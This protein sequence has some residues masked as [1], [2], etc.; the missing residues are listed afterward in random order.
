MEEL[1]KKKGI[2]SK[3]KSLVAKTGRSIIWRGRPKDNEISEKIAQKIQKSSY[4]FSIMER[5]DTFT[6]PYLS[7]AEQLQVDDDQIFKAAAYNMANIAISRK[8]YAQDIQD[9]FNDYLQKEGMPEVRRDYIK[10]KQLEIILMKKYKKPASRKRL[11]YKGKII[12][13]PE[14]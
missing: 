7:L 9:I 10:Q 1:K 12:F 14:R 11:F 3:I 13:V 6:P 5:K 4:D 2:L 8:K